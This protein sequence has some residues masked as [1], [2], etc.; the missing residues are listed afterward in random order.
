MSEPN[1]EMNNIENEEGD[2]ENLRQEI[3]EEHYDPTEEVASLNEVI[4]ERE[5]LEEDKEMEKMEEIQDI[6]PKEEIFEEIISSNIIIDE[7]QPTIIEENQDINVNN[8]NESIISSPELN[9]DSRTVFFSEDEANQNSLNLSWVFGMNKDILGGMYNL[10]D[11]FR[12][13]VFYIAGHIGVIYKYE[14]KEQVLLQGHINPISCCNV[15]NDKRWIVTADYGTDNMIVIWDSIKGIPVKTIFDPHPIGIQSIAI[16][17]DNMLLFSL[18]K[19]DSKTKEQTLSMWEWTENIEGP[20][21]TVNIPSNEHQTLVR[22]H[23]NNPNIILT[24]G[25]KQ[26][27][28]W[29]YNNNNLEYFSPNASK[30]ELRQSSGDYVQTTFVTGTSMAVSGTTEGEIV[31]WEA[32]VYSDDYGREIEKEAMKVV[33]IHPGFCVNFITCVGNYIVSG[34]SDGFVK[35]LDHK[36]RLEAWFEE[37]DLGPIISISFEKNKYAESSSSTREEKKNTEEFHCPDFVIQTK[38]SFLV[39]ANS[40]SFASYDI[41]GMKGKIIAIGQNDTIQTLAAHPVKPYLAISGL[42]GNI[43]IW[44][45][46]KKEVLKV[47]ILKNLFVSFLTFDPRGEYLAVGCTNG[48]VKFFDGVLFTELSQFSFRP[49][50][51]CIQTLKFSHDS[52]VMA[53]FDSDNC[54]GIFKFMPNP[55]KKREAT[56]EWVYIGRFKSH[57]K[58]ITGLEFGIEPYGDICRLMSVGEDKRLI[59][60]DIENS[61]VHGG[62]KI[63]SMYR[64]SQDSIPTAFLWYDYKGVIETYENEKQNFDGLLF[65]NDQYKLMSFTTPY[66]NRDPRCNRTVL[67]P[68]YGGPLNSLILIPN[69]SYGKENVILLPPKFMVYTTHEK[70]VGMISLPLTGNPH[71]HNGV[72]AHSGEITSCVV[73]PDGNYLFTA[74]GSDYTVNQWKIDKTILEKAKSMDEGISPYVSLIEGGYNGE[75]FEEVQ[76]YFYYAQ[77][78]SQGEI[79]TSERKITGSVPLNQIPD[80][81][82]ALGFYA[83]QWEIQNMINELRVIKGVPY[84]GNIIENASNE[85]K[86]TVI[87]K[88][89]SEIY[90]DF[91]TFL[92]VYVNHRPVFG[93][94]KKDIEKAFI[95]LGCDQVS[96]IIQKEDFLEKLMSCGEGMSEQE[97][98]D[99]FSKLLKGEVTTGIIGDRFTASDFAEKVLGFSEQ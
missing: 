74:G 60:Y 63:K 55:Q 19:P 96:R 33:K 61:S 24:T 82:R 18:S 59:E 56:N 58:P 16:S 25:P 83:T 92:K 98:N 57:K 42:S 70:V 3:V 39:K 75:F 49:S 38:S 79:T 22:C 4:E 45:Y 12:K 47:S 35:F 20:I 69:Y 88:K 26:V 78:R 7:P 41:E 91:D 37:F 10:S 97:M 29:E 89:D 65:A 43:H 54:V 99:C 27:L 32:K 23:H 72:I 50:K 90:I 48:V 36:L 71:H 68:S 6:N 14:T 87:V 40:A 77:I 81:V 95:A 28:F 11:E 80:L 5:N 17:C 31:L 51:A 52:L 93:I 13:E 9:K 85:K 1:Q 8:L 66:G 2:E 64:I 86:K 30:G 73:S 94:T 15:S 46:E 21:I 76:Q 53:F 34:G 84:D 67:S 44:D 62:V